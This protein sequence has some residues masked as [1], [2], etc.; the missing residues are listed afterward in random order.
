MDLE[1]LGSS[2]LPNFTQLGRLMRPPT[3]PSFK[4]LSTCIHV[5]ALGRFKGFKNMLN[6]LNIA[7]KPPSPHFMAKW[8]ISVSMQ[9]LQLTFT[10]TFFFFRSWNMLL[11]NWLS[12][13][14]VTVQRDCRDSILCDNMFNISIMYYKIF[15]LAF[16]YTCILEISI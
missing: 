8:I 14:E 6:I 3:L 9:M 11:V 10:V 2:P 13:K 5:V 4:F 7:I 16:W 12:L 15:F 1:P